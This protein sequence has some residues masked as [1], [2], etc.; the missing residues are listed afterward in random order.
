MHRIRQIGSVFVAESAIVVGDVQLGEDA[1][2]W[3]YCVIRGDVA[4][5]RVGRRVNIQDGSLL[6]CKHAVPLEIADDVAIGHQAVVHCRRV[7]SRSL[8]AT[9]AVLLDDC[10]V[11]E[12][13]IVAAG[14]VVPPRTIIPD[15][16]VVMGVPA[17]VVRPTRPEDRDYIRF[18]V[19]RYV[20]QA[21]RHA[22]GEFPPTF[23]ELYAP[24]N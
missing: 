16:S 3:H 12:D 20:E 17:K 24:H 13:C 23:P 9:R 21:R 15:G 10:E 1:S 2:V 19:E 18:V 14:A 8:I 6:H 7:G 22:A 5:I 4:P 11:G